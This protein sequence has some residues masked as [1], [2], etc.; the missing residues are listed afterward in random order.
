MV[1]PAPISTRLSQV[2]VL[3]ECQIDAIRR[4][5]GA[6]A[7][8]IASSWCWCSGLNRLKVRRERKPIF[9]PQTSA[10]N[11]KKSNAYSP[12][13]ATNSV[14][15]ATSVFAYLQTQ[16]LRCFFSSARH[17]IGT[18]G[19]LAGLTETGFQVSDSPL[20][21]RSAPTIQGTAVAT[22]ASG[23]GYGRQTNTLAALRA[24][25][26]WLSQ[27]TATKPPIRSTM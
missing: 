12:L 7:L 15:R 13:F 10:G 16:L 19:R 14:R 18:R 1:L 21:Q 27:S 20:L 24:I 6:V 26:R 2:N 22:V 8:E 23:D 25:S 4:G 3:Y 9:A 11:H 17:K 5:T